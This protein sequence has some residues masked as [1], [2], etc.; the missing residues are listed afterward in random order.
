MKAPA[1]NVT[2]ALLS[3]PEILD[4][5]GYFSGT[6]IPSM[7]RFCESLTGK[8]MD[9]SSIP[10][11]SLVRTLMG[12]IDKATMP[13]I[14]KLLPENNGHGSDYDSVTV[15]GRHCLGPRGWYLVVDLPDRILLHH[16]PR[17]PR[18]AEEEK[19][20][21]LPYSPRPSGAGAQVGESPGDD[22]R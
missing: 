21:R 6:L 17:L 5:L 15:A 11:E 3:V 2:P 12:E 14:K 16:G 22:A 13:G 20:D 4:Q 7:V 10:G 18:W 1:L 8:A 9:I 19:E